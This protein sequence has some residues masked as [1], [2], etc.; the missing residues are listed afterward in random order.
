[1]N[2]LPNRFAAVRAILEQDQIN[3]TIANVRS[4]IKEE[5]QRH[6]LRKDPFVG[7]TA[8]TNRPFKKMK[9]NLSQ[10]CKHNRNKQD[11]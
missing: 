5:D 3:L 2:A 1:L 7:W 9:T 8:A 10:K 11:C 6:E 4:K